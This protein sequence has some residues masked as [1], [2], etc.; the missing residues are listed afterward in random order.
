[1]ET[2]VRLVAGLLL[3]TGGSRSKHIFIQTGHNLDLHVSNSQIQTGAFFWKFNDSKN[4]IR[5]Y[6]DKSRY[7][8][9]EYKDRVE[10]FP[11][12]LSLIL[13][14]LQFSDTGTYTAVASEEKDRILDTFFVTDKDT[15]LDTFFVTVEAPVSAVSLSLDSVSFSSDSCNFI[16]SCAAELYNVSRSFTCDT[17]RCEEPRP[18]RHGHAFLDLKLSGDWVVCN[19]SNH[20][21]WTNDTRDY[22]QMCWS[23]TGASVSSVCVVKTAVYCAG[24]L[25]ML[26]AVIAVHVLERRAKQD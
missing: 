3:W 2:W 14:N 19:H 23:Q 16:A 11:Q 10:F 6:S 13:K 5:M 25:L 7:T 15:I 17:R 24:L 1:M 4:L 20:V 22:R 12:N 9:S 21:S 26:S 18:Q 8:G